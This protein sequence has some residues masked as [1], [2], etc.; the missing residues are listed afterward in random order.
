MASLDYQT[1]LELFVFSRKLEFRESDIH[2]LAVEELLRLDM[3]RKEAIVTWKVAAGASPPVCIHC[4]MQFQKNNDVKTP[5]EKA[6]LVLVLDIEERKEVL[7]T[8]SKVENERLRKISW[9]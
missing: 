6:E 9:W 7:N 3:T 2:S 5:Q 1:A 8:L 4:V